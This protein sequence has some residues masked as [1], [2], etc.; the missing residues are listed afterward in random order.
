MIVNTIT[1]G[2]V[3]LF[4]LFSLSSCCIPGTEVVNVSFLLPYP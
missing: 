3:A 4:K 1:D 2:N